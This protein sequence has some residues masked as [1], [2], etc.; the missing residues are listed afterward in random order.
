MTKWKQDAGHGG[1]DPGA[2]KNGQQE[3]EWSL[4]AALYV[5]KRLN[6]L[7]ISSSPTRTKDVTL[8]QSNRTGQMKKSPKGISHHFNAGGGKGAE[9]IH[10]VYADGKFEKILEAEFKKIGH[11]F[12]RTFTR[13]LNN[14]NDYYYMHRETG[15]CRVTIVEYDFLDGPNFNKLKSK[16]YREKLYECVVKAICI[17]E[18]VTYKSKQAPKPAP[19]KETPKERTFYRVVTGSFADSSNAEQRVN[20]LKKK[21]FDSFIDVFEK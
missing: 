17:E 14:G 8:A 19:K 21:G 18:G 15:N 3:K 16:T 11:D 1:S 20:E 5:D 13:K 9:L 6:E 4:E 7:G 10:S 2:V 12:R